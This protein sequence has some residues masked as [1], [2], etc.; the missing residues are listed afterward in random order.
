MPSWRL[1]P[2]PRVTRS[3][4]KGRGEDGGVALNRRPGRA[5]VANDKDTANAHRD[6]SPLRPNEPRHD[7]HLSINGR[8]QGLDVNDLRLHLDD[9]QR[10]RRRVPCQDVNRSALAVV[11][12]RVFD[13]DVPAVRTEDAND[14]LG[15]GCVICVKEAV[16]FES[17]PVGSKVEGDLKST[18]NA[19]DRSP[20]HRP[21]LAALDAGNG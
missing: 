20:R 5:G 17:A 12:E 3:L 10:P 13:E 1:E 14:D 9:E 11:V 7:A 6:P 19:P 16:A 21:E 4:R 2:T 15:Y 18:A 8:N